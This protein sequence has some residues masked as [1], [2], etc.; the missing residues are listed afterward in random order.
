MCARRNRGRQSLLSVSSF[1]SSSFQQQTRLTFDRWVASI[2]FYRMKYP[3][4][5]LISQTS[6]HD[7]VVPPHNMAISLTDKD[8]EHATAGN[9]EASMQ[10]DTPKG[11]EAEMKDPELDVQ[12]A[13][14]LDPTPNES[15][16]KG[17][18]NEAT[19]ESSLSA[20][21]PISTD[22]RPPSLASIS[23]PSPSSS[24]PPRPPQP[25]QTPASTTT[26]NTKAKVAKAFDEP[27][28]PSAFKSQRPPEPKTAK[29][30]I[31]YIDF[32]R[33]SDKCSPPE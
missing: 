32:S 2:P 28:L 14:T 22:D 8:P 19:P 20:P 6:K 1:S 33:V 9:S 13:K 17:G 11:N 4:V 29:K 27:R 30:K 21:Q 5:P 12:A 25:P 3:P 10:S 24:S 18:E 26:S 23:S 15:A 31:T 16:N 7:R